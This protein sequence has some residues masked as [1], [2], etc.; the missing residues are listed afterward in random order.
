MWPI[1]FLFAIGLLSLAVPCSADVILTLTPTARIDFET[2]VQ[3]T[4]TLTGAASGPG[5]Q[6]VG[7]F[8]FQVA[9]MTL[10]TASN[11]ALVFNPTIAPAT[12][13]WADPKFG[14]RSAV[15][16]ANNRV[17]FDSFT[18]INGNFTTINTTGGVVGTFDIVW[19]RPLAGQYD[20]AIPTSAMSGVYSL[21]VS[22]NFDFSVLRQTST[23]VSTIVTAVPEPSTVILF[24]GLGV[25]IYTRR[26]RRIPF[27]A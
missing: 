20:A 19:N 13:P 11:V 4:Y 16:N 18:P 23:N 5:G 6:N 22:G 12:S 26:V 1:R 8:I 9:P 2:Q 17:T 3:I 21:A 15:V 24:A 25:A 27:L 14:T 10:P 7:E